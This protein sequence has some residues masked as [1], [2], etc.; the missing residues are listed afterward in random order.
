MVLS[1]VL[2]FPKIE[3]YNHAEV[4]E[5]PMT[6]IE[7]RAQTVR[8]VFLV[9]KDQAEPVLL[10]EPETVEV[11][12]MNDPIIA[13]VLG[14]FMDDLTPTDFITFHHGEN[15]GNAETAVR[16]GADQGHSTERKILL[17]CRSDRV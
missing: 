17:G 7:S 10:A 14:Q 6:L 11:T 12:L 4:P 5:N 3:C 8:L 16:C 9:E 15:L 2:I 13:D 1:A